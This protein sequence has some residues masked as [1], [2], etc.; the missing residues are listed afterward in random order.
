MGSADAAWLHMDRPTNLMV[1]NA[2][3]WLDEALDWERLRTVVQERLVDPFPRFRQRVAEPRLGLGTPSW[4]DYDSFDV[5]LHLHRVA[6]PAPA[7]RTQ[8]EAL[9]ADRMVVAL[10]RS[11]ALWEMHLIEGYRGGCAVHIRVHHAIADGIALAR[12][13]L[14]MTDDEDAAGTPR[15]TPI[16]PSTDVERRGGLA[17]VLRPAR[18]AIG[19]AG[20]AIGAARS[21]AGGTWSEGRSLLAEPSRAIDL[22]AGARAGARALAKVLVP[23]PDTDTVLRGELGVAQRVTWTE[24]LSLADVKELAHASGATVNDVLLAGLTGA[25]RRYL[26]ARDS[27]V[28]EIHV[29]V[30]F[31]LRPLD[32]PLP[33]D[34]G[35]HFG[36]VRLALPV[37]IAGRAERLAAVHREM[38]TIKHSPEGVM[39]YAVLEAMGVTPVQVE[40]ALVDLF[41]GSGSAVVTNVPGPRRRVLLA[42]TPV[43]GVLVWAPVA[44]GMGISVSIIS[45]AGEVTVGLMTDAALV[46]DPGRIA[47]GF[48]AEMRALRTAVGGSRRG[49]R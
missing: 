36:L 40:S 22:A 42:G 15:P 39:A 26:L 30:P 14:S 33:R 10:D 9:V 46:P 23:L 6:L 38:D 32:E 17:P 44:G 27:L 21:L 48:A 47:R 2:V 11:R 1:V 28:D 18:A 12:V 3:L 7:D 43:R 34:L 19:A 35:N 29:L 8:L 24:P 41:S 25:L 16:A 5:D 37:G 4:E 20:A 31:N 49:D 45:Y 13:L